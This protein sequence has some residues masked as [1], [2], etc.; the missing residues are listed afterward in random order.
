MNKIAFFE[1]VSFEQFKKDWMNNFDLDEQNIRNIYDNIKLP[2][3]ATSGSAGYDIFAPTNFL[4]PSQKTVKIPTGIRCS[5]DEGW[6][7]MCYPRSSMGFKYR[8]QLDN[9]C[10]VIDSDF[11]NADN[12]G[13]IFL[14]VSCDAYDTNTTIEL[15]QGDAFAQGI[16]VPFGITTNDD[17][18]AVRHGGIGSTTE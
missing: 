2:K 6:V 4:I 18:D 3:R 9:T 7:L 16:F 8:M 15:H 14:K 12:E 13:H 17:T 10:G 11:Y 5:I 1:K